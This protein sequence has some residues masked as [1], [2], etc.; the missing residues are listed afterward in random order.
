MDE[1]TVQKRGGKGVKCYKITEKSGD[2]VGV[3]A[4]NDDHE[5]MMIT[6]EGIIIQLRAEDISILGRITSGVKMINLDKD[7][8]VAQ[9]AKVREKI[10]NGDQVFDNVDDALEDIP[11]GEMSTEAFVEDDDKEI[12]F[13]KEE[14]EE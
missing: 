11:E 10:S 14:D 8:K 7:V 9:I 2:V 13:P 6:T 3:K 1:F 12:T 5:I 4:V